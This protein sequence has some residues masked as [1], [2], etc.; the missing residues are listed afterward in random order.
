[1]VTSWRGPGTLV[2]VTHG[3]AFGRLT[4]A[5]LE[6]AETA[7]LQPTPG[8]PQGGDLVGKIAPPK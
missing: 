3:L 4:R 6:Q 5:F 8:S 2:L 1:M 7:V